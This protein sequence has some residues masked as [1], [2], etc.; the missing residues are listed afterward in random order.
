MLIRL[1]IVYLCFYATTSELSH[2]TKYCMAYKAE[3]EYRLSGP[4]QK[5]FAASQVRGFQEDQCVCSGE[6]KEK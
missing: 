1:H 4:L 2:C 5:R 3:N 6:S